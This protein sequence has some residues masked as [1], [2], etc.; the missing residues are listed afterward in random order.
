M[1]RNKTILICILYSV[2]CILSGCRPKGILHSWEMKRL[3]V[4][5]HKTDALLQYKGVIGFNHEEDRT[6]YYARVL[7]EHGV[8][9]AQFDSSL[10]WYTAHPALFDKIYPK[11]LAELK[12]EEDQYRALMPT[13]L[14]PPRKPIRVSFT[15]QQMDSLMWVTVHGL[16]STWNPLMHD[17][18]DQL[19]PEFSIFC[20][21]V[22]DS[23][24]T[25][26]NLP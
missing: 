5:L 26:V 8:T 12:A 15:Q 20:G 11:V 10:V 17:S 13:E 18:V 7:E 21:G 14:E 4:D 22:V 3:L 25:G 1:L 9:Q 2:L 19:L 23:L 16:P 6:Y 24:Q